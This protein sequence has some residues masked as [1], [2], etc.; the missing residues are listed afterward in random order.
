MNVKFYVNIQHF[1]LKPSDVLVARRSLNYEG[2]AK[3]CL[4]L[5]F[6]SPLIFESSLIRVRVNQKVLD[7]IFFFSYMLEPR[8]RAAYVFPNVTKSTISGINQAGLKRVKIMLPS[9][10]I[11]KNY[12]KIHEKVNYLNHTYEKNLQQ[13]NNLFNSLLQKAFKGEL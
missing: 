5:E 8:A 2:S 10:S 4:I 12:R 11:Q 7:P 9:I 6:D 13:S 1:W 3:P